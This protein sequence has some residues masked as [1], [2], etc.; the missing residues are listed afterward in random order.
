MMKKF[1]G[2]YLIPIIIFILVFMA[3]C[4]D[5]NPVSQASPTAVPTPTLNPTPTPPPYANLFRVGDKNWGWLYPRN[6]NETNLKDVRYIACPDSKTCV[7]VS[8]D[9]YVLVTQDGGLN[10]KSNLVPQLKTP[11][12][13][14]CASLA[15]CF[16][17]DKSGGLLVT[18]DGGV[19]WQNQSYGSQKSLLA[20]S[21][22]LTTTCYA[23]G[24]DGLILQTKDSGQAWAAQNSNFTVPLNKISCPDQNTCFVSGGKG[25]FWNEGAQYVILTT[26][27]AGLSW[28]PIYE[29]IHLPTDSATQFVEDLNC[30]TAKNCYAIMG[31]LGDT[32]PPPLRTVRKSTDGGISWHEVEKAR[33]LSRIQCPDE[34]TCYLADADGTISITRDGGK[35]WNRQKPDINSVIIPAYCPYKND[36]TYYNDYSFELSCPSLS[37][38]YVV[39]NGWKGA[40]PVIITNG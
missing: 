15:T 40:R 8:R 5:Q 21:C 24:E 16:I 9:S 27:D 7:A 32:Y 2:S 6:S 19:N 30:P 25:G 22:P 17:T 26:T 35:S 1:S 29:K 33:E 13:I 4:S 10:W 23:V 31:Y 39:G 18:R 36:C 12:S 3:A 14:T 28:K 20:I 38:C 11:S 34:N 37:Q